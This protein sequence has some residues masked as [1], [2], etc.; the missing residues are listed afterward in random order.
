MKYNE[1]KLLKNT[2]EL[3]TAVA[4]YEKSVEVSIQKKAGTQFIG[5]PIGGGALLAKGICDE[6]VDL[7]PRIGYDGIRV[8]VSSSERA[9]VEAID[10][11]T[12]MLIRFADE[13]GRFVCEPIAPTA[14]GAIVA[15]MGHGTSPV[16]SGISTKNREA[17]SPTIVSLVLNE[18]AALWSGDPT[19]VAGAK[20][21]ANWV[22]ISQDGQLRYAGQNY[23]YVPISEAYDAAEEIIGINFP[24]ATFAEGELSHDGLE[25]VWDLGDDVTSSYKELGEVLP[26]KAAELIEGATAQAC[27]TTSNTSISGIKIAPRLKFRAGYSIPCGVPLSVP[28]RGENPLMDFKGRAKS[29]AKAFSDAPMEFERLE[30]IEIVHPKECM[31][32]LFKSLGRTSEKWEEKANDFGASYCEYCTALDILVNALEIVKEYFE[33]K[34]KPVSLVVAADMFDSVA[35]IVFSTGFKRHY[36]IGVVGVVDEADEADET[37]A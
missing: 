28:H 8:P 13:T 34:E 1:K 15:R 12:S 4:N 31:L 11:G 5:L 23:T 6:G 33:E 2:A 35:K 3:R 17:M 22:R 10:D 24:N 29:V 14:M 21:S 26:A 9:V 20:G 27:F 7:F 30:G 32:K 18:T 36:D 25:V 19:E 16:L 37:A